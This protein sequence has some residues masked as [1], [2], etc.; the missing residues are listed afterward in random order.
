MLELILS[1]TKTGSVRR[2]LFSNREQ[3]DRYV[4][5]FL[6]APGLIR[7]RN[8]RDY[9]VELQSRPLQAVS[10]PTVARTVVAT[11][12]EPIFITWALSATGSLAISTDVSRETA[13]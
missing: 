8:A 4:D 10:S 2:K 3:A 12:S 9:R 13:A 7:P 11:Q 6:N 1:N 5:R